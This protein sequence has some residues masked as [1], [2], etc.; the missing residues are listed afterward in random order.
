MS[1]GEL[2]RRYYLAKREYVEES[3]RRDIWV[4]LGFITQ[5]MLIAIGAILVPLE[6]LSIWIIATIISVVLSISYLVSLWWNSRKY[7]SFKNW[8]KYQEKEL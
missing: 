6:Y 8:L 4:Y 1:Y 5:L 2:F 7:W 3:R